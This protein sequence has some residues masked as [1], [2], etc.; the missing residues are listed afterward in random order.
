MCVYTHAHGDTLAAQSSFFFF[1]FFLP[2]RT[3]PDFSPQL[4]RVA[5]SLYS[6]VHET[7]ATAS[8]KEY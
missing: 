1:F 5:K 2:Q 8:M 3:F 6:A 4:E 7:I